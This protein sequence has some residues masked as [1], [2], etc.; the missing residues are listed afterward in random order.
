MQ[1][2]QFLPT[3]GQLLGDRVEVLSVIANGDAMF[4]LP[5]SGSANRVIVSDEGF[6][7]V[8]R[9]GPDGKRHEAGTDILHIRAGQQGLGQAPE[10]ATQGG[11]WFCSE[12][13]LDDTGPKGSDHCHEPSP[14]FS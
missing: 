3:E 13:H 2:D 8:I 14:D 1:A 5:E 10:S 4:D 11:G 7:V 6:P 12:Y 9:F